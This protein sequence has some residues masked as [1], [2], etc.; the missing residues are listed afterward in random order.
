MHINGIDEKDS[1]ILKPLKDN[2][3]LSYS[4]IG[5]A[6]DL[7]RTAVKSRIN[8]LEKAGIIMGYHAKINEAPENTLTFVVNIETKPEHFDEARRF[9]V[10][11]D[12]TITLLHTTGNCHLLA[13]CA[14]E[15]ID[16]MRAYVKSV[17]NSVPGIVSINSHSILEVVKGSL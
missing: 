12:N 11:A 15:N 2:A 17:Y 9:F 8:A 16:S 10:D 7:S 3:R 1:M 13:L 6:V 5:Q 14:A 4:E